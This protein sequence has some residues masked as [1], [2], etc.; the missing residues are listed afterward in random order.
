MSIEEQPIVEPLAKF[1]AKLD[2]EGRVT[3]PK[4]IREALGLKKNDYVEVIIR[5]INIDYKNQKIYVIMQAYLI[6][7][8]GTKGILF[9][10][11]DLQREMDLQTKEVVEILLVGFHKF[12]ELLSEKGKKLL[13]K[14]QNIGKWAILKPDQPFPHEPDMMYFVYVFS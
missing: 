1:H 9:L 14:S 12:E 13:T 3:I 7:R 11:K 6:T 4:A 5:K 2:K 10:P 8:M